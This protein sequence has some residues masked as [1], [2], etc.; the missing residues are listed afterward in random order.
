[1][2]Q[3]T[4]KLIFLFSVIY[5]QWTVDPASPQSLGS[6]IQAQVAA[7]SDGGVYVAWM[8]DGNNYH[9]YLQRLNSLGEPQLADNGMVVSDNANASWIAV[10]HLN[11]AV[12]GD[13]NAIITA[14]DQRTGNWEVY[15]WKIAPDGSML[16]GDDGIQ[17]SS[18]GGSNISP[19]LTVLP[20]NSVVVTWSQDYDTVIFQCI[21]SDGTLMWGTGILI[22]DNSASLLSPQPI[23]TGD[24]E[25]LIQWI[26]QTGPV[27]A[28]DSELYLQKYDNS[29]NSQWSTPIVAAGPVVFPMG[30]WSQQSVADADSGSFAAW[31]EMSGNVQSA[32]TQHIS[33]DGTLSWTGGVD[34]STN[35]SN[36]HM[37]PQLAVTDGTQELM[38]VWREANGSQTQRG[39]Y[40][41]R[42]DMSG[43]R[44]WGTSGTAV[45]ELNSNYDYLDLSIAGF[46]DELIAAYIEQSVNMSGDIYAAR[47][48]T[49]GNN[50]WDGGSA[51]VTSTTSPKSDMMIGR[52]PGC[53]FIA[54]TESGSIYAHC[55]RDDGTLGAPD[56]GEVLLVPSEYPSIQAA[57]DSASDDATVLVSPGTYMENINFNGKNIVVK[58]TDGA[59]ST[60][61]DGNQAGCVV[62]IS[63]STD[64]AHLEGFTISN[65][66]ASTGGGVYI[67]G[68]STVFLR[69]LVI[70]E[71][72]STG[73]GGGVY[74]DSSDVELNNVIITENH[75][76]GD[77]GGLFI[78]NNSNVDFTECFI[79]NNLCDD[80]GGGLKIHNSCSVIFSN[81]ELIANTA[82]DKGGAIVANNYSGVIFESSVIAN[83]NAVYGA[84]FRLRTGT[85]L[86]LSNSLVSGNTA[87]VSGGAVYAATTCSLNVS[88][89]T[90]TDNENFNDDNSIIYLADSYS[91]QINH[92]II[93]NE[94]EI[95]IGNDDSG[96]IDIQYSCILGGADGLGN[97]ETNPLFCSSDSSDYTVAENS[98][99][100]GSGEDGANIGAF[101]VGCGP[102]NMGPLWHVA[103]T[104]S[105]STGNGFA[106]NPFATIQHGINAS[107]YGDTVLVA[108]GIYSEENLSIHGLYNGYDYDSKRVHLCSEIV[109]FPDSSS[110]IQNTIIESNEINVA[111]N[112][113]VTFKGFTIKGGDAP[114][115]FTYFETNYSELASSFTN[116]LL[117][118]IALGDVG[119]S[120]DTVQY[121]DKCTIFNY[122]NDYASGCCGFNVDN[123]IIFNI[124]GFP[125]NMSFT[126]N[127]LGNNE[128]GNI[129]DINPL[130]CN[131]DSG[132]YTL[133]ENSPCV[134]AGENGTN[135]G[136]LGVGC[137]IQVD[138][139]F[140]ISEPTI[141][142]MGADNEWN[143][144]DTIYVEMDF[145]NNTDV[146]HNWY[147]GVTVESDS[148]L[149]SLD[150]GHIWFYA[151][152]AE[153]CHTISF[154][155]LANSSII[156]DTIV[157]F[158]AYP[159]ALNC[160]N[161][162][163]YCIDSDTL[164]FEVPILVPVTASEAENFVPEKFALHQNY[165]N[166]FNPIT[167][168]RYDL[169]ENGYVNVTVYDMLGREVK[170]LINQSQE[171]GYKS[172]LWD[173]TNN[174]GNP[175][176]A[177]VYLYQIHAGEFVQTRKMV[178]LK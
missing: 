14:V 18:S 115:E 92:S 160:E 96:E 62:T 97:I 135:I 26:R 176:S 89:S 43:N 177:G 95:E 145:C 165:P 63:S 65:G 159:E 44:L 68:S 169:P 121:F 88:Y 137:P 158:R 1:L 80:D 106:D 28:A 112:S 69:D 48:D 172:V 124:N 10:Y 81:S 157:T 27:W 74:I 129:S 85:V 102:I 100:L 61:I 16:W 98:P 139:D 53:L 164:I 178:L 143:P 142:V 114:L 175:V 155:V 46:G 162:P 7:T 75:A 83:N 2:K 107:S 146:A 132:D 35:S 113:S 39:I 130:F 79:T 11:L 87:G 3:T 90:I 153:E 156:A 71:N 147:P 34:L 140:S 126:F 47:L 105:D 21:S 82:A 9:I 78:Y 150:I 120:P 6:G 110:I 41:Q 58:T 57:I 170:S 174:L 125:I 171:A 84:A 167:T 25:V 67:D 163:G 144:G 66:Q 123:S 45:V 33:G 50:V 131:P 108:S 138:W 4:T 60:I 133:A 51:T 49:D 8:S 38:A 30:N 149:T 134:G 13:D 77:G 116:C 20:D 94:N 76:M 136:A 119:S 5:G 103:T 40:A 91:A 32:G 117:Y 151:M 161:Q 86:D 64:A 111:Y 118:D 70:K 166:P 19:R 122:N 154:N 24:G 42:L 72:I 23:V 148:S 99:C 173:A 73:Q 15:A 141:E 55:L 104:G 12:D 22:A 37:S 31:T 56:V 101:G 109:L 127:D 36:F 152:D 93:W 168:L 29:G 54:W 128:N 59:D 52:G 17:L